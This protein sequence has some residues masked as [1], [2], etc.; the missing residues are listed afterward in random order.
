MHL[1]GVLRELVLEMRIR[2]QLHKVATKKADKE[3]VPYYDAIVLLNWH[4]YIGLREFTARLYGV[5]ER[6]ITK[7]VDN[8]DIFVTTEAE[9]NRITAILKDDFW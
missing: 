1:T 5:A 9:M 8:K 6:R 2:K 7:I 3:G 4:K